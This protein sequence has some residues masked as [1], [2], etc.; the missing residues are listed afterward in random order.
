MA[1]DKPYDFSGMATVYDVKCND[2]RTIG[3]G[4][5]AHQDGDSVPLV[6]RH[7]HDDIDNVLGH[8]ILKAVDNGIRA[9]AHFNET[10]SGVK[11]KQIVKARNIRYLSIWANKVKQTAEAIVK[12]GMIREVSLVFAGSNPGAHIDDVVVS[13]SDDPFESDV[14]LDGVVII[15]SG[16][17]IELYMKPTNEPIT[18]GDD[19][20]I[21]DILSGLNEKQKAVV[22]VI[23]ASA[24]G[25]ELSSTGSANKGEETVAD[26]WATF[27]EKQKTAV[28]AMAGSLA[29][30]ADISQSDDL[31]DPIMS[32]IFEEQ[33]QDAI[34]T[35]DAMNGMVDTARTSKA[36]SLRDVV[37]AHADTYGIKDIELLFPD[38]QMVG[39]NAPAIPARK[40]MAWVEKVLGA[41]SHSPFSRVKSAYADITADE[42]R[43]RGY[44]TGAEKFNEVFP[45]FTRVT[46]PQTIYKKSKLDRD[47]IID[48]TSFDVV[49]WLKMEMRLKLREEVARAIL[50]GDGREAIS[51]DKIKEENVRP[52]YSDHA[53]YAHRAPYLASDA[54]YLEMVDA[55]MA[56]QMDYK[57]SGE[58]VLY[59][60]RAIVTNMLLVRDTTNRR[61]HPTMDTL[62]AALNVSEI[63][64]VT[65]MDNVTRLDGLDTIKLIGI[66]VDLRDY[67]IGADRGGETTF[68]EDFDIDFNQHKYLLETRISGALTIP[69]SAVIIEQ[70]L[71]E[72]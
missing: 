22:A 8:V 16:E 61:I 17:E 57:G 12:H 49:V 28:Y 7:Q 29:S 68:F 69:K 10:D 26:V 11:A 56:A 33:R 5:F 19:E 47:D 48:V 62:K 54:T 64:T 67:T 46:T 52:I 44:I 38:A 39:G 63:V 6:W 55:I 45:V 31:G 21:G 34:L 27:T 14:V 36:N 43:A 32:N 71:G 41:T 2:G 42:A 15:H 23:I 58:P 20:T 40:D 72:L 35:H 59:T 37:L 50:I 9:F 24:I 3:K 53:V 66:L 18:H 51:P 70:N 60:T 13:H 65:P 1:D 25:E 4:A 30:D